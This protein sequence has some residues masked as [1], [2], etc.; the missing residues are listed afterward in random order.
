[1]TRQ[2]RQGWLI[3][4]TLFVAIF[5]VSGAAT[6][7]ISVFMTP[8]MKHFG[9]KHAEASLVPM[10]FSLA[11][12]LVSPVVGYLLDR[13]EARIVVC[14]GAILAVVGL[15]TASRSAAIGPMVAAYVAM[16]VGVSAATFIP[17]SLVAAN[18][19][20]DKR[21]LAVGVVVAGASASGITMPPLADYLIRNF[22]I[23]TAFVVLAVPIAVI[24]LP[25]VVL[26]V[27]T[28]PEGAT[29][30]SVAEQVKNLPG[31][32]VGAAL[33]TRAFWLLVLVQAFGMAG[34]GGTFYH[35]VPA[36]INAGYAP[37]NAALVMSAQAAASVVGF[38][39]MG[40]L[41]DRF[42]ARRVLPWALVLLAGS[43]LMLLGARHGAAWAWWLTGFVL[44]FGLTAGCTSSL[45]PVVAVEALGLRRFGTLWG[46]IGLGSTIGL[47]GG[48]LLV[49]GVFDATNSYALAFE[50]CAAMIFA[51]AIAILPVAPAHGV[52]AV[53]A[54]E[55]RAM[56][57]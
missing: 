15:L 40:W 21:G 7:C 53:P 10:A 2:E 17:A 57:H 4:A 18:W 37:A 16:G 26:V 45:T 50:L 12:G 44:A 1:M 38:V 41:A 22:G 49:G 47:G 42:T 11:V 56:R 6:N 51:A 39:S 43:V 46:L 34:L 54:G 5:F 14:G 25:L 36:L 30:A 28:R 33:S 3:I 35:A 9:W 13:L 48:P 20:T 29:K 31:L 32:E 19:F 52:E 55:L 24:V 27:R 23:A 8:F